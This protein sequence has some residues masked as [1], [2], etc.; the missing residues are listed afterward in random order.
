MDRRSPRHGARSAGRDPLNT[1][2]RHHKKNLAPPLASNLSPPL[3]SGTLRLPRQDACAAGPVNGDSQPVCLQ[4]SSAR[5]VCACWGCGT[6]LSAWMSRR[7]VSCTRHG[8]APLLCC[9]LYVG[10][11]CSAPRPLRWASHPPWTLGF[12]P[13]IRLVMRNGPTSKTLR[14]AWLSRPT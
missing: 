9:L 12:A 14:R 5:S 8:A 10:F 7:R 13:V 3:D 4:D 6:L 1:T 2:P 11:S